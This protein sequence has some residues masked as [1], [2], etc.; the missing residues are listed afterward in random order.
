[1]ESVSTRI[2]E[3]KQ[4]D[5]CAEE[6][7]LTT[8]ATSSVHVLLLI[9]RGMTQGSFIHMSSSFVRLRTW[10][11]YITS[12]KLEDASFSRRMENPSSRIWH[13]I[14]SVVQRSLRMFV[15][16]IAPRSMWLSLYP[17]AMGRSK[18]RSWSKKRFGGFRAINRYRPVPDR[19]DFLPTIVQIALTGATANPKQPAA[20]PNTDPR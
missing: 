15:F 2:V 13:L 9:S 3:R 14:I 8:K 1:M 10:F 12:R 4:C 17:G 19:S 11:A 16:L 5:L 20:F 7:L 18:T 6:H